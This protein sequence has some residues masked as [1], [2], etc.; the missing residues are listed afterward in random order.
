MLPRDVTVRVELG[1][2]R[3][4]EEGCAEVT[5]DGAHSVLIRSGDSV[6]ISRSALTTSLVR[7]YQTSFVE[8]LSQKMKQ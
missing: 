1:E 4:G 7:V 3:A 2:D 8:V 6:I 5:F